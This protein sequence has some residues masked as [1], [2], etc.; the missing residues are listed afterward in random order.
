MSL[1]DA[2]RVKV[3][4][5]EAEV[6]GKMED[7]CTMGYRLKIASIIICI[8]CYSVIIIMMIEGLENHVGEALNERSSSVHVQINGTNMTKKRL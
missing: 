5:Q 7:T 6:D 4:D 8:D 3:Y 2:F 1:S